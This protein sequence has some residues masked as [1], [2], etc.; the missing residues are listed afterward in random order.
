M[1]MPM[2]PDPVT[3]SGVSIPHPFDHSRGG[4]T[5]LPPNWITTP[6]SSSGTPS[7]GRAARIMARVLPWMEAAMFMWPGTA[8]ATWG[9][10]PTGMEYK[11][12][13]DAFAAKLN[14]GGELQWNSFLGSVWR[15]MMARPS[16]WMGSVMFSCPAEA[17]PGGGLPV[18]SFSGNSD[19]FAA[20]LDGTGNLV[21]N[22]FL[23]SSSYDFGQGLVTDGSGNVFIVGDGQE[24]WG[25]PIR[26]F[27]PGLI[28]GEKDA[29]VARLSYNLPI[30]SGTV[31][32]GGSGLQNVVLSG[33]PGIH[34]HQCLRF[35]YRHR[36]PRLE[37]D[38]KPRRALD[39]SS[40]RQA[41]ITPT[42]SPIRIPI[43]R[44]PWYLPTLFPE[45]CS[46]AAA[47][48]CRGWS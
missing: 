4:A 28:G 32:F 41:Q 35:L 46:P 42:C 30:I 22:S 14:A 20:K 31:T 44:L 34:R 10:P 48:L 29:F 40:P 21:W 43:I 27:T 45:R 37:R 12:G 24:E 18:N 25:T 26:P 47:P 5:P 17:T 8:T 7:W 3:P 23:G 19:A 36:S 15:R 38:G 2:S 16:L 33:L 1:A 13:G 9:N 39:I 6:G 11:G